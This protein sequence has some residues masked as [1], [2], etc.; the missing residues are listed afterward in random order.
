MF[1]MSAQSQKLKPVK[2]LGIRLEKKAENRLAKECT[3]LPSCVGS[4][5]AKMQ[6][7]GLA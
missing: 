3:D 6:S 1:Q 7:S 2:N 4:Y 5:L